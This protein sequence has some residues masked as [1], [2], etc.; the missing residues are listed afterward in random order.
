MDD[1]EKGSP[2]EKK[3][4]SAGNKLHLDL[5]EAMISSIDD[6]DDI[7]ELKDEVTLPPKE[8]KP[9]FDRTD[10]VPP[11]FASESSKDK[12]A[13]QTL[14]DM[15]ALRI[16]FAEPDDDI[17]ENLDL[18][19]DEED[20]D[21]VEM[22]SPAAEHPPKSDDA[23]EV[24]EITEFDDIGSEDDNGMVTLMD[25]REESEPEEEF[26]E[27]IEVD[28]DSVPDTADEKIEEEIIQFDAPQEDIE[29]LELE[30]FINDSLNEEI[31]IGEELEDDLINSLGVESGPEISLTEQGPE[32]EEFNFNMDTSEISE[33][34]DQ[35]DNI[36]FD[37]TQSESE[38]EEGTATDNEDSDSETENEDMR[39]TELDS[40][41]QPPSDV[42]PSG[43]GL[44]P[45]QEEFNFNMD[46]SEISEKI[47]QLDNI[48]FDDT[49]S[50]S[51]Y[52][53]RTATDNEDNDSETENEDMRITELDSP[54]QPPSDVAPSGPGLNP[55][56]IEQSI[57][58]FIKQHYSEKIESMITAIIE[59]AVA[60]EISR[61]KNV[62]LEDNDTEGF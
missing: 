4:P 52:E 25:D 12:P 8:K 11:D 54:E 29:D 3:L 7:I 55:D 39:I 17:Q 42:A 1:N 35:L 58:Q 19:F 32:T 18:L 26:L 57:E 34:I 50:E 59:K 31:Q 9:E 46:T 37:D 14:D 60:K 10:Q 43:P 22:P 45:D 44:N 5:S 38:Y 16:D 49:Q 61:L 20:E 13:E 23:N 2:E 36:F 41:E 28:Q 15:D 56:Q 62:L 21:D 27:L 51:E 30:N 33:K 47:D 48:F 6:D 53:E 40:P 24:M